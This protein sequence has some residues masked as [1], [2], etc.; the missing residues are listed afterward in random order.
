[1]C[2][3]VRLQTHRHTPPDPGET[4]RVLPLTAPRPACP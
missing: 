3:Q 1:M 4:R 2:L